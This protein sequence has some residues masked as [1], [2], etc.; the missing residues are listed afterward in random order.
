MSELKLRKKRGVWHAVGMIAG[1]E[2]DQILGTSNKKAAREM[3]SQLEARFWNAQL[4]GG[5]AFPHTFEEA[6]ASYLKTGS[7]EP[8]LLVGILRHFGGRMVG[9]I[10][11]AEVREMAL[12]L[13]PKAAP[14][15]R[16]RQAITPARA[17]IN[18]AHEL[19]WCG[20]IRVRSFPVPK[21]NK[22]TPV[23]DEWMRAFLA[24]SDRSGLYHLSAAVMFMNMTGARVAEAVNLTWQYVDLEARTAML[25]KTK[26]EEWSL[27]YMPAVLADRIAALDRGGPNG[28]VFKYTHPKSVNYIVA[29]VCKRAGISIRTSHSFGRHSFATN[30]IAMGVDVK[31][32]MVAGGWKSSKL[33]IEVYVDPKDAQSSVARMIDARRAA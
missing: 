33:F 17:V 10:R 21:S 20:A 9:S 31:S 14:A 28:R 7:G 6:A 30:A 32:A 8:H 11:P 1:V 12:A 13:Y 29:R 2:V 3:R 5:E 16:N 23:D 27:R 24:E 22:H 26:T 4:Y 25:A 18:H 15:T 19:G